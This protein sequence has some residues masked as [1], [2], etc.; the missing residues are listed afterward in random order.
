LYLIYQYRRFNEWL[1]SNEEIYDPENYR[2]LACI[3]VCEDFCDIVDDFM[4][5]K[6]LEDK[7][8]VDEDDLTFVL[9]ISK[10]EEQGEVLVSISHLMPRAGNMIT[11]RDEGQGWETLWLPMGEIATASTEI[12]GMFRA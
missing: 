12:A 9:L 5:G 8:A 1:D 7:S 2:Y 11:E 4:K 3:M 6:S 10:Y